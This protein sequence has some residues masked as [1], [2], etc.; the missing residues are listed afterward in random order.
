LSIFGCGYF[1]SHLTRVQVYTPALLTASFT[2]AR[3]GVQL[4]AEGMLKKIWNLIP[5]LEM[6]RKV[7]TLRW[8]N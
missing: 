7:I 6:L 1:F 5:M 2:L 4:G 8:Y 3:T